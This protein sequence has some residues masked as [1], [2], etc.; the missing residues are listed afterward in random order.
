MNELS[1]NS[2]VNCLIDCQENRILDFVVPKFQVSITIGFKIYAR[3]F[4]RNT[5]SRMYACPP[6][7]AKCPSKEPKDDSSKYY[8]EIGT[9][10]IGNQLIIRMERNKNKSKKS[11]DWEPPCDCDVVE[12][13]RPSSNQGPKILKGLDN[14]RILFRVESRS[15][16]S[17]PEDTKTMSQGIT[18]QV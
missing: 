7:A 14:N 18:Y 1:Y 13:Q 2:I 9:A 15:D 8:R 11:R 16:L 10:M 6:M 17:K 3:V 12:I 5:R 4:L